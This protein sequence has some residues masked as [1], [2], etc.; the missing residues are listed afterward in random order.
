M[1]LIMERVINLGNLEL[2]ESVICTNR[3]VKVVEGGRT[4]S[5]STIAVVGNENGVVGYGFGKSANVNDSITKAVSNAK[6]NLIRV[7]LN[8]ESIYHEV[9]G[10]YN[11]NV[12]ILRPAAPGAGIKCGGTLKTVCEYVGIKNVLSKCIRRGSHCNCVRAAFD[13]LYQMKDPISIAKSRHI[14][15]N[16]VFNG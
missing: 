16:K 11:G 3:V 7:P 8:K 9:V 2:K 12:V 10:R 4:F 5:F 15:L 6:K 13:A 1:F 14:P